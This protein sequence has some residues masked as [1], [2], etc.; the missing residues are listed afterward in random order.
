MPRFSIQE[1]DFAA[2][3]TL[4]DGGELVIKSS[5]RPYGVEFLSHLPLA[6][7]IEK[8][9]AAAAHPVILADRRVVDLYLK[10]SPSL[11][12]APMLTAEAT[13]DF[14][15]IDGVMRLVELL[16][17][18]GVTRSSTLFVIGGGIIQDVG[19][20]AG[21]MYKRGV[22]WVYVPTTLLSQGDSCIGGKTGLN[23]RHT[24][25]LLALFSAPRKVLIHTGFL[26]T[27]PKEEIL[28]GL[29]ETFRLCITGGPE[30]VGYL[31]ARI[32]KAI[33][34][35]TMTLQELIAATLSVKRAVVEHDEFELDIRR[36]MNLGHSVGHAFEAITDHGIPHGVGVTIGVLV[37]NEISYARNLLSDAER[38]RM[39]R[40]GKPLVPAKARAVLER[41]D[42]DGIL[43]ILRRDKKT[44]GT[45][46]KLVVVEKIGQ[47]RFIDLPLQQDTISV[48]RHAL[49]RVLEAL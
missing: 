49:G 37:E 29:G 45:V 12:R 40:L 8:A 13:E 20:F 5:P 30:F 21:S 14:K 26:A 4:G 46:L 19:A 38:R 2:P 28:S 18:S 35:D 47:I 25:N 17:K 41:I 24:K 34:A 44:E 33:A 39:L 15:T 36:S 6:S 11:A 42:L 9:I 31:E 23:H 16:E 43:D 27:L 7:S 1:S 22:P 10:H 48:L 32:E 3:L